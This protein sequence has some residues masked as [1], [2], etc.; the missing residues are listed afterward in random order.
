MKKLKGCLRHNVVNTRAR[1]VLHEYMEKHGD[2]EDGKP[3]PWPGTEY[4]LDVDDGFN[5]ALGVPNGKGVAY[6]LATHRDAL[7]WKEIYKICIFSVDWASSYNIL[8][9]IRDHANGPARRHLLDAPPSVGTNATSTCDIALRVAGVDSSIDRNKAVGERR[10]WPRADVPVSDLYTA[11]LQRGALLYCRIHE[12][13]EQS[14]YTSFES[15]TEYGWTTHGPNQ[16]NYDDETIAALEALGVSTEASANQHYYSQHD[17]PTTREGVL[18]PA[19][20]GTYSNVFNADGGVIV[21]E[22]NWAPTLE[23]NNIRVL[24]PLKQYSDVVFLTWQKVAGDKIKGLKYVIRHQIINLDTLAV[25]REVLQRRGEELKAWPGVKISMPDRDA[26]AILGTP[27]GR[28]VAWILIQHK[29]Q[30]GP[31]NIKDVTIFRCWEEEFCLCFSIVDQDDIELPLDLQA[32]PVKKR[33]GVA[34]PG[35]VAIRHS[36]RADEEDEGGLFETTLMKGALLQCRVEDDAESET[37]SEWPN[38]GSLD[39]YGWETRGGVQYRPEPG[40]AAALQDLGVSVEPTANSRHQYKHQR[41]PQHEG[42]TYPATNADYT[43]IFNVDGGA[44]IGDMNIGP[45]HMV[46]EMGIRGEVVPL[47]QYSDVAFLAWQNEAGDRTNGLR[48]IIKNG[49]VNDDT[50]E[51]AEHILQQRNV[52]LQPWPGLKIPFPQEDALALMGSPSGRGAAWMLIQ[53]KNQLGLKR[54]SHVTI[55]SVN[56]VLS[57]CFWIEDFEAGDMQVDPP[58]DLRRRSQGGGTQAAGGPGKRADVVPIVDTDSPSTSGL[59]EGLMRAIGKRT[60][61]VVKNFWTGLRLF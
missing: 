7:G 12:S 59:G 54:F 24:T 56:R 39:Y 35:D 27:N 47:K 17:K 33:S 26:L 8:Y 38:Y 15:L 50:I 5:V 29:L 1:E 57:L 25:L 36:A 51:V 48:Y 44:I 18:Y 22:G 31:K 42:H 34:L 40:L 52:R 19:S 55:F 16:P 9:Y 6:L 10:H 2:L 21:A 13:T 37:P 14:E 30:L 41:E 32:P 60:G 61:D 45:D 11:N 28:G 4:K 46:Q 3:K 53:H 43:N 58:D 49:I 20:D 23:K